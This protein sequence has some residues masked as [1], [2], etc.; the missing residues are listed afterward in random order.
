MAFHALDL[1]WLL[2]LLNLVL[3]IAAWWPEGRG[4]SRK[5]KE[6]RRRTETRI[7]VVRPPTRMLTRG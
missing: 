3:E 2:D 6:L 5:R 7:D 1:S 4:K